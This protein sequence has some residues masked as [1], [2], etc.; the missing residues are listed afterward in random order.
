MEL[1]LQDKVAIVTGG[2]EGIGRA[3]AERL[4]REGAKV[5][6]AARRAEVLEHA[7]EEIG[8]HPFATDVTST[9]GVNALI[10]H[11]LA[12]FG[13]LDIVVNNAGTSAAHAFE[14]ISDEVWEADLD[15]KLKAA[16]RTIRAALPALKRQGGRVVNITTPSGKAP[17]ARSLPTS[18]SRAAGIALTKALSK[19]LA[20]YRILVNTVCV[21]L[22]KSAQQDRGAARKGV[23]I[24]QHYQDLGQSVP[25]GRVG[26]AAEVANVIA[27]LVSDAASYVT[28]TSINVDGGLAPTV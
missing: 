23:S 3:T 13:R 9:E 26:E 14:S 4:V 8:A 10:E 5:V 1:G 6:I 17:T 11:T 18:V 16:V 21:G 19:E 28:G 20:E 2:S 27:F 25:L 15:L 12:R 24:E 22:I 7:A